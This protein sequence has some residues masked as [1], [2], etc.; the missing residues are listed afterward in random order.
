MFSQI[1]SIRMKGFVTT[2]PSPFKILCK[3]ANERIWRQVR[4]IK[5]V[6]LEDRNNFDLLC[7]AC[8]LEL[9]LIPLLLPFSQKVWL[10]LAYVHFFMKGVQMLQ[11]SAQYIVTN[12][13]RTCD[14]AYD[15]FKQKMTQ[16]VWG[17]LPEKQCEY[18]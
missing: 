16:I 13:I 17:K 11:C 14:S 2:G 4:S 1:F 9:L 10:C 12:G 6:I 18:D 8:I 3:T 7:W 15:V 5:T